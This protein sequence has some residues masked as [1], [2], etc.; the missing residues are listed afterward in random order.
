RSNPNIPIIPDALRRKR[1][2][3]RSLP[4]TPQ[5]VQH[6]V[7]SCKLHGVDRRLPELKN[8]RV[9]FYAPADVPQEQNGMCSLRRRPIVVSRIQ[10]HNW[11]DDR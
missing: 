3:V 1:P 2:S 4:K 5:I 11:D 7:R 9:R 6:P 10:H 8:A